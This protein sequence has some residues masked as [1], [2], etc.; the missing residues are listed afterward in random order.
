LPA[1]DSMP[2]GYTL[3]PS[4]ER[5]AYRGDAPCCD[6]CARTGAGTSRAQD[7]AADATVEEPDGQ[8][9]ATAAQ[10]ARD[11]A[12]AGGKDKRGPVAPLASG[13][14][15]RDEPRLAPELGR[16]AKMERGRPVASPSPLFAWTLEFDVVFDS[17]VSKNQMWQPISGGR[18]IQRKES[19]Q[20]EEAFGNQLRLAMP[21]ELVIVQNVLWLDIFVA[22]PNHSSDA[23]N[24]L[25]VIADAI[26]DVTGLDDRW[27]SLLR[28]DWTVDKDDP[29]IWVAMG[30]E[31][32]AVDSQV[33][34]GCGL[35]LPMSP[36][37]F[38]RN[39]ARPSGFHSACKTCVADRRSSGDARESA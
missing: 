27:Y 7:A 23:L 15:R 11:Q 29:R 12:A 5:R 18:M 17:A 20:F 8:R 30:Q 6:H 25:D 35:I 4:C 26:Q 13:A 34:G 21:R 10:A 36:E 9:P 22:K 32:G 33:C 24:V 19:S 38:H 3:C 14:G 37:R 28:L 31:V 16:I 1:A 2:P 39:R